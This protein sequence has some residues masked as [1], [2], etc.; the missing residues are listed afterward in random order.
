MEENGHGPLTFDFERDGE[1]HLRM[2]EVRGRE[3]AAAY[4]RN[5]GDKV[6][7]EVCDAL[8]AEGMEPDRETILI[9]QVLLE[10]RD[11]RAVEV[12]PYA[13]GGGPG[14]GTAWVYDD[15]RVDARLLPSREPGGWYNGPC[16]IGRFN[17]HY[18]GGVA[19]ELGHA[20]GLPHDS[21]RASERRIRGR[22]L[23]GGGNHTY[24]EELRGEGPG[25]FLSPASTLPRSV[26]PL[27]TGVRRPADGGD[28]TLERFVATSERGRV[29]LEGRLRGSAVGVVAHNNPESRAGT[30]CA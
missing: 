3:P 23:M 24:G 19:H 12:G 25:T 27:F 29:R 11:G 10:G 7:R 15:E 17:T 21:E 20:F 1:G 6:R 26:H 28:L 5:D 2:W 22:S 9:F 18:I 4:G 30:G 8:R 14:G 16:S 13:G